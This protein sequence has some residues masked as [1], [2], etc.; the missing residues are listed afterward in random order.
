MNLDNERQCDKYSIPTQEQIKEFYDTVSRGDI[1]NLN[2][3]LDNGFPPNAI[4]V[5]EEPNSA[6]NAALYALEDDWVFSTMDAIDILLERGIDIDYRDNYGN[7]LLIYLVDFLVSWDYSDEI[8][9]KKLK[10][11]FETTYVIRLK[12]TFDKLMRMK[13]SLA[14]GKINM[15]S[16]KQLFEFAEH[17]HFLHWFTEH[18]DCMT[19]EDKELFVKYRLVALFEPE[20]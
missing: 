17:G 3:M 18:L 16:T 20:I 15:Q 5:K 7:N 14:F 9:E 8:Y 12:K 4:L 2:Y 6:V 10:N 11:K 1:D 13:P 19:E